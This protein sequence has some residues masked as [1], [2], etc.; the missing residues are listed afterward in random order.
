M[1]ADDMEMRPL[2]DEEEWVLEVS[3]DDET[4]EMEKV[5][6]ID[7]PQRFNCGQRSVALWRIDLATMILD[8]LQIYGI[9]VAIAS[10]QGAWSADWVNGTYLACVAN[11]DVWAIARLRG[12]YTGTTAIA[13]SDSIGITYYAYALT[14]ILF[15]VF[16]LALFY[17]IIE[18]V[19][20][21][22]PAKL[23]MLRANM[24]RAMQM[25]G[26][27]LFLPYAVAQA[28]LCHCSS[29]LD[30][31]TSLAA[32]VMDTDNTAEC[33]STTH[34][35][36]LVPVFVV[37]LPLSIA[38]IVRSFA[39]VRRLDFTNSKQRYDSYIRLKEMEYLQQTDN[40]WLLRH[41]Y[42]ISSYRRWAM[43]Y[44]PMMLVLKALI[45]LSFALLSKQ[46]LAQSCVI[47]GLLAAALLVS[48]RRITFRLLGCHLTHLALLLCNLVNALL[49][50]LPALQINNALLM[51]PYLTNELTVSNVICLSVFVFYALLL[52]SMH[53]CCKLRIWPP[54]S[55]PIEAYQAENSA[56]RL[57]V[58]RKAR[59]IMNLSTR[60]PD[61]VAPSH[62]LARHIQIV[63]A[64]FRDA[65]IERD[66]LS[67]PLQDVL[68]ELVYL[69]NRVAPKSIF[70]TTIK[71]STRRTAVE[72]FKLMPAFR[73]YMDRREDRLMLTHHVVGGGIRLDL[74]RCMLKAHTQ[75]IFLDLLDHVRA[76][77]GGSS[78]GSGTPRDDM[79]TPG[80]HRGR[81]SASR[82]AD[83]EDDDEY[84]EVVPSTVN[85]FPFPRMLGS[86]PRPVSAIRASDSRPRTAGRPGTPGRALARPGSARSTLRST[87]PSW[88]V[89]DF[90]D[91]EVDDFLAKIDS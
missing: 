32:S 57:G 86:T 28:R 78:A 63:N 3:T 36:R 74:A 33:L 11:I 87:M 6:E 16:V 43:Y 68:D 20:R 39:L 81:V 52:E 4:D 30:S 35:V 91:D 56:Y 44:K 7:T 23:V 21:R 42:L 9:L 60:V 64:T 72:L 29:V 67:A 22:A 40:M 31:S 88:D 65:E 69:H 83:D 38:F 79:Q 18:F 51:E 47:F 50:M 70:G 37:G 77:R 14:I 15:P 17:G 13:S 85:H 27:I 8:F 59:R 48:L 45:A 80:S 10:Y 49:I 89:D 62:E 1:H 90:D 66:P 75:A 55:M 54:S 12:S 41:I 53:F 25:G 82:D 34:V 5:R 73:A 26:S 58:L 19:R 76:K 24:F 61:V 2:A 84:I 71:A 46:A